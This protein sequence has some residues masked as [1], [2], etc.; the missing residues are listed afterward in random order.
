MNLD[1]KNLQFLSCFTFTSKI[2]S[3]FNIYF[4]FNNYVHNILRHF[5][6]WVNFF[7]LQWKKSVIFSNK[8][9]ILPPWCSDYH[10][11]TT[12]YNQSWTQAFRK[13]KPCSWRVRNLRWWG[14]LTMVPAGNKAKHLSSVNHS[15]K[16]I[17]HHKRV[18]SRVVKLLKTQ[19]IRKLENIR[20]ISK[21]HRIIV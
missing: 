21:V 2:L 1:K 7:S 3:H 6:R 10:H 17:H 19:N 13:F 16:T 20:K 9:D 15:T 11:C 18:A 4:S 12:S 8:Q 5:D 14:S